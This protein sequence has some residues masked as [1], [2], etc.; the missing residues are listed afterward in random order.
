MSR[1]SKTIIFFVCVSL[2]L[3]AQS[4]PSMAEL[5]IGYIRSDY[6]FSKYEPY[7]IAE[8]QLREFQKL[9]DD[10]LQKRID[11]WQKKVK[12]AD[13]KALIMTDETKQDD[14]MPVGLDAED[15]AKAILNITTTP[16]RLL[17]SKTEF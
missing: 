11:D 5:K 10:K 8:K 17:E 16:V 12:D 13:S 7:K 6:I 4:V 3:A 15:F 14:F 9:E 2:L 1:F